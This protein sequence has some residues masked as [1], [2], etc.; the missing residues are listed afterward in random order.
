MS[1]LPCSTLTSCIFLIARGCVLLARLGELAGREQGEDGRRIVLISKPQQTVAVLL[2]SIVVN[3]I[4]IYLCLG[5][6]LYIDT[7]M[8]DLSVQDRLAKM[9]ITK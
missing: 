7:K 5:L 6:E 2:N 8:M 3:P 9:N 1:P 4:F